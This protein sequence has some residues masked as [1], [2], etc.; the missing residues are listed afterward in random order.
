MLGPD[1]SDVDFRR[2]MK[3]ARDK[4]G[5][6]I[7]ETFGPDGPSEFLAVSTNVMGQA[8]KGG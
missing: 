5:C 4:K 8:P 1:D 3:E 6:A 7:F 2:I